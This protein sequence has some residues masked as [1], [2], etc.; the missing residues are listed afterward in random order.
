MYMYVYIYI[1][2]YI[3]CVYI[4]I[5]IY[6]FEDGDAPPFEETVTVPH[7]LFGASP[8]YQC[9]G[10]LNTSLTWVTETSIPHY[11]GHGDLNTSLTPRRFADLQQS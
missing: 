4:Y 5:Y 8:D 11:L 3:Y 9:H 6:R 10:D 7:Y 1:Y 2:I